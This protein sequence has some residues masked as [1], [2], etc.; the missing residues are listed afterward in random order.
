MTIRLT[1]AG[2]NAELAQAGRQDARHVL[3]MVQ[4]IPAYLADL[5]LTAVEGGDGAPISS[6]FSEHLLAIGTEKRPR[7]F[8]TICSWKHAS[9]LLVSAT[10]GFYQLVP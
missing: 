3:I 4:L 8:L 9:C 1:P 10:S 2:A 7:R 5:K 6:S